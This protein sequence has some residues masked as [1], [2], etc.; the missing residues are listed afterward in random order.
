MK[1]TEGVLVALV[2]VVDVAS[3][4]VILVALEPLELIMIHP[5]F[6]RGPYFDKAS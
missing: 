5:F 6:I 2:V 3:L 1:E 4:R